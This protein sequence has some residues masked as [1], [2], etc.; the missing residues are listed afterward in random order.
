MPIVGMLNIFRIYFLMAWIW[1]SRGCFRNLK[2]SQASVN[3]YCNLFLVIHFPQKLGMLLM[4]LGTTA[5]TYHPGIGC[6]KSPVFF[7]A[8]GVLS[9]PA[10][11][12]QIEAVWKK[13]QVGLKEKTWVGRWWSL[14]F[15]HEFHHKQIPI[16]CLGSLNGDAWE[17]LDYSL[18]FSMPPP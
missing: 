2:K 1:G 4:F 5:N 18:F 16:I 7:P 14:T 8:L 9:T 3:Q 11:H 10:S 6:L 12:P 13:S 15:A 17:R